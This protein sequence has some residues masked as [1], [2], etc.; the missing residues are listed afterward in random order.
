MKSNQLKRRVGGLILAVSVLFGIGLISGTTVQAQWR[1]DDRDHGRDRDRSNRRDRNSDDRYHRND[2][3]R[4]DDRYRRNDGYGN[5]GGYGS[6]GRYG[7]NGYQVALNQGYQQGLYTGSSDAQR[8][9]SYNPQ[10]S[11]Y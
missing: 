1:R 7:N 6:N 9:Q 3:Y 10:R 5:Y 8:G 11:H 4:R 2:R